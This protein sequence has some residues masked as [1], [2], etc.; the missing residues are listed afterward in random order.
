VFLRAP[1][2]GEFLQAENMGFPRETTWNVLLERTG[3]PGIHF[4]D[5]PELQG[6]NL[7]EWS[8]LSGT[9]AE[10]FTER[11]GAILQREHGWT[12]REGGR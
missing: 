4:E 3:V 6:L 9:D 8:H 7:P 2:D 1:S 11:L 12:G 5:Y 10:V